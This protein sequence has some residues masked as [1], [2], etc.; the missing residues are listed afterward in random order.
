[1]FFSIRFAGLGP[2]HP[3][4]MGEVKK[5]SSLC[6]WLLLIQTFDFF[7]APPKISKHA[8]LF[9]RKSIQIPNSINKINMCKLIE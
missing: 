4:R 3:I 9:P 1:V 8:L 7:G 2:F 5:Y 6:W